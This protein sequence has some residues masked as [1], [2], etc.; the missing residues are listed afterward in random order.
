MDFASIAGDDPHGKRVN[1][2]FGLSHTCHTVYGASKCIFCSSSVFPRHTVEAAKAL[3]ES[4]AWGSDVEL[5]AIEIE[6]TGLA[7]SL[8]PEPACAESPGGM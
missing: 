8:S 7:L 2:M 3:C 1:F 6:Q 4:T 5:E